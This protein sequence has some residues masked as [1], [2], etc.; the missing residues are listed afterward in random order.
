MIANHTDGGDESFG[1]GCVAAWDKVAPCVPHRGRFALYFDDVPRSRLHRRIPDPL[2]NAFADAVRAADASATHGTKVTLRV[3]AGAAWEAAFPHPCVPD[4]LTNAVADAVRATEAGAAH[5]AEVMLRAAVGAAWE[6][7]FAAVRNGG[8]EQL[9]RLVADAQLPARFHDEAVAPPQA[10]RAGAGRAAADAN[11]ARRGPRP[12]QDHIRFAPP[13]WRVGAVEPRTRAP[14][15][16]GAG[17]GAPRSAPGG[18]SAPGQ[19][20]RRAGRR[21]PRGRRAACRTGAGRC[22]AYGAGRSRGRA[23]SPG[24][25][26]TPRPPRVPSG[27]V[28]FTIIY[29]NCL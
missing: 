14:R 16:P 8:V 29:Y 24:S 9:A 15:P 22:G 21:R 10:S 26:P 4:P 6:A 17:G 20:G 5:G 13:R 2:A 27:R 3:A 12:P 1:R 11:A 25:A 19:S 28:C 7:A 23:M 18:A